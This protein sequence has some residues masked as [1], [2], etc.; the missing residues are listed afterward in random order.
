M[1]TLH[2]GP[3]YGTKDPTYDGVAR[4]AG[5][6][7][8][9]RRAVRQR[10]SAFRAGEPLM[11]ADRSPGVGLAAFLSWTALVLTGAAYRLKREGV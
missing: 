6:G 3:S 8:V 2:R 10:G 4:E 5:S 11:Y 1:T 9:E 7:L